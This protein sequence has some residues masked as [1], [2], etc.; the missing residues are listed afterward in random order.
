M[1]ARVIVHLAVDVNTPQRPTTTTAIEWFVQALDDFDHVVVAYQRK[2]RRVDDPVEC[3][4]V[5]YRLYHFPYQGWPFGSGL[6]SS[7][8]RAAE[9]TIAMLEADGIRPDLIH[10]HKF[11]F[12]GLA[13]WH[14]ARHFG[15]PLFVSLRGEVET[16]VFR[17]KPM[18]RP[19]LRRIAADAARLYFVS[20]WFRDEFHVHVPAQPNKERLLPNIV[21]N[22]VPVIAPSPPG[23]AFVT[24]LNLDTW[25]RKGLRWLLDGL[26]LALR[27]QPALRLEIIGG[28]ST[29]AVTQ[30]RAMIAQRGLQ[31][32]VTLVGALPNADVLAR[33]PRYRALLL[34]SL[35]ETF[36]M[37]LVEALFAGVPILFTR[38]TAI[39]GYLD[40]LDVGHAVP[41]R[42]AAAIA[43]A[44]LDLWQRG[45]AMREAIVAA[46]PRLF[47]IF[48]PATNIARYRTDV[49]DAINAHRS[50]ADQL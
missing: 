18:L 7:M 46:A 35:N 20:A 26:A 19:F 45:P 47:A 22:V 34:P 37:V 29:A 2:P 50:P 12:E 24:I 43:E 38:G 44:I 8:R 42:N 13:G 31:S 33:L 4:A 10:A 17:R 25:R 48:D 39:D 23:E 40:G 41:P 15:V 16:K 27:H 9:R 21:R 6:K 28:G 11:T 30:V 1:S 36:G 14:V 49:H 5:G 3:A 32:A